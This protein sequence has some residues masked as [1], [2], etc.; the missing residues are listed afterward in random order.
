MQ[1]CMAPIMPDHPESH[2]GTWEKGTQRVHIKP[3]PSMEVELVS[4]DQNIIHMAKTD[5]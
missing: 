4:A 3:Q 5:F 2:R 1:K